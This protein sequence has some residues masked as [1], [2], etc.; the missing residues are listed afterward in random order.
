M[1]K[2]GI[3]EEIFS[4]AQFFDHNEKYLIFYRNFHK[5]YKQE[6]K[7][8]VIDSDNFQT[9]PAS[10]IIRIT[11]N[12]KILFEKQS[13]SSELDGNSRENKSHR[14]RDGKDTD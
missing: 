14:R 11:K 8:F 12:N 1:T 10:R 2:K 3:V 9:I 7:K 5:V 6:L 13:K 4:K